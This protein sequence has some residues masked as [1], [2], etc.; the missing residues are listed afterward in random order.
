MDRV[1]T[2]A[3]L[4]IGV[5]LSIGCEGPAGPQGPQGTPGADGSIPDTSGY[6]YGEWS[7]R[8]THQRLRSLRLGDDTQLVIASIGDSWTHI[9]ARWSTPT[10]QTLQA[11]LGDAGSGWT[12]FGFAA[13]GGLYVNG[14]VAY[15][16]VWPNFP[17]PADWSNAGYNSTASPDLASVTS[18]IPGARITML[19][20]PAG[21]AS[22]RLFALGTPDGVVRYRWSGGPWTELSVTG[23]G[24]LISQLGGVPPD[25]WTLDLEVA[26]GTVTLMGLDVQKAGPGVR[27]HKLAGTGS[28]AQHWTRVSATTWEAGLAALAPN[29]VAVLLGTNDQTSYDAEVFKAHV[30]ELISRVRHAAPAADILLIAPCENQLAR[31]N[32]MSTYAD[33]LYELA[34]A[35]DCAFMDLQYVFGEYPEDYAADSPR[36]WFSPDGL[37]PEPSTGGR[38]I[39]DA[40]LRLLVPPI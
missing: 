17:N 14:T 10:A 11:S 6:T 32:P 20:G 39:A 7:L 18:A 37:H 1:R 12:G 38:A 30:Q 36:P 31:P 8:E 24:P 29:L 22:V 26:S 34:V 23:V 13:A 3:T 40:V 19:H 28:R 33:A 2:I 21:C 15:P 35:N 27:W 4:V 9:G 25:A 16:A 5:A